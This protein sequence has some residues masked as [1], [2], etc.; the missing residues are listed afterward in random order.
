[1]ALIFQTLTGWLLVCKVACC[2]AG[3]QTGT[4]EGGGLGNNRVGGTEEET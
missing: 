2:P 1:M 4:E 3:T